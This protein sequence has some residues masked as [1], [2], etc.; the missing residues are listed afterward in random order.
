ML[1]DFKKGIFFAT[2]DTIT[3]CRHVEKRRRVTA[4]IHALF[5]FFFLLCAD[6]LLM[7]EGYNTV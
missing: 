2:T 5:P 1:T 7:T 6:L 4:Y 3:T